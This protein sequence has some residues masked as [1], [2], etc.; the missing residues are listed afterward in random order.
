[1]FPTETVEETDVSVKEIEE[2]V[3][4]PEIVGFEPIAEGL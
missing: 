3:A 4:L 1:M 2:V